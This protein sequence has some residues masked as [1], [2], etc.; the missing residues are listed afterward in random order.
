MNTL[1]D[2][3]WRVML[4]SILRRKFQSVLF[5]LGVALG[6]ALPVAIDLANSSAGRAFGLFTESVTGRTTHQILAE[7]DGLPEDLYR[8]LRVELG[9]RNAA[10]VVS[11][12]VQ[13]LE[14][15][16]Q[17]LRLFGVDPFAEAPFRGYLTLGADANANVGD[18]TAFFTQ[19]NTV[20]IA[21]PLAQR[22]GLKQG[23]TITLR[24]GSNRYTVTIVGLLRPSD[25]VTE[26]GLQDLLLT[27]ISTAQELLG[28]IGRLSNIDLII[29]NSA[30][31]E[32]ELEQI[33]SIL[34]TGSIVQPAA[35]RS[36][37][38]SQMTAA[39]NL[40]LT[41]LSLL[42]L[43]VG[44]FLIYNTVM[45]SVVQR[46]PVLGTL[47]ALG[48]TQ[49]Q[50]FSLILWEAVL[51]SAIG[52]LMGIV[53]GIVMGR[54]A[55]ILVTQTVSSLY[56]TVN[57][58][59]VA[60]PIES[61][62]KGAVIGVAAAILAALLPAYEATT[63]SPLGALKR[64]NIED[65]TRQLIPYITIAG[66]VLVI[67]SFAALPLLNLVIS[68]ALLFGIVIGF[69]LLTPLVTLV[70]MR[71][72]R[73]VAGA[74]AGVL[75]LMAP[76]SI[77][78]SLSRTSVAIAALM[79]SV[80]VI[81][82][83]SAM[84]GSFRN[85]VQLW[86]TNSG[87][88]DIYISPPSSS[89]IRQPIPI[90]P[91]IQDEVAS[92][93]GVAWTASVRQVE[94]IRPNDPL[95]VTLSAVDKDI[96]EGNRRLVWSGGDFASVWQQMGE[97]AVIVSETLAR[98]RGIEIGAGQSI[99]LLTDKG[100]HTFP[101]AAVQYDYGGDQG[102]VLMRDTIYRGLWN[103]RYISNIAAFIEPN[104]DVRTVIDSLRQ[105]FAGREE[106]I[107][108]SGRE[109]LESVLVVFDQT[110]AITTALNMLATVVAFIGILSALM[111]LQLERL[112]EIGTMRANGLTRGQLF[113][114]TLLETGLMGGIAGVMALPVGS[115]LAWVLVYIINV[116][117]FGWSLNLQLRPEFFTQALAV[118]LVAS[119]L[120]G[121]YPAL[122][123]GRIEPARAV[124]SE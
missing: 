105:K 116:R 89:A 123:M 90:D 22:Y 1:T 52:A 91:Q 79:V 57:V 51:L 9:I 24:Y 81:V 42:A 108:Q 12:Y 73:P 76:R 53:A 11:A 25:S 29:P 72:V 10:P 39:F 64:S 110:F 124:R 96:S 121:I 74:V 46:R 67:V 28:M 71:I 23:D 120:A 14:L 7:P 65:K 114:L 93:P 101:I 102:V 82:G 49:G 43:V 61:L 60:I 3:L 21:E 4:R 54:L 104:A 55:V 118:A 6:V 2:S 58:R 48:V 8:Q 99:T 26:Q 94:V 80:S 20:L 32:A 107:F 68:F 36:N 27:D 84:V 112:R 34:P 83:V 97:G 70:L 16:A 41:A 31:G 66:V 86:L 35:A 115:V 109:L 95:P 98:R 62:V 100:E 50:V 40:S 33:H 87:R 119:L 15:D 85:D 63:T 69:A 106:L 113:R 117:S 19:P 88:A 37:A 92:T 56:F 44:M 78:R 75:G 103:D 13:A 5:I 38:I 17:P 45:F 18:I 122:R 111:A 77:V 30:A 47:R 59:S